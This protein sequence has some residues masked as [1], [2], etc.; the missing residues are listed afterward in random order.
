MWLRSARGYQSTFDA[1]RTVHAASVELGN[2]VHLS[3]QTNTAISETQKIE[4]KKG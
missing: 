2:G 1:L 4:P 3:L